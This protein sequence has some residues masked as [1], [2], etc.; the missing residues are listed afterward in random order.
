MS[1]SNVTPSMEGVYAKLERSDEHVTQLKEV[2]SNRIQAKA[3]YRTR[4]DEQSQLT[5]QEAIPSDL[6]E[7]PIRARIIMGDA[8]HCIAASLDH[9]VYQLSL[10]HTRDIARCDGHRTHFPIFDSEYDAEGRSHLPRI[11]KRLKLM[12]RVPGDIIRNLQPYKRRPKHPHTDPLWVLYRL[13]VIDKHRVLLATG[14]VAK[15]Q[16]ITLSHP[17]FGTESLPV[18]EHGWQPFEANKPLFVVHMPKGQRLHPEAKIDTNITATPV[19]ANTDT[20]VDGEPVFGVLAELTRLIRT[21]VIDVL[22]G[23]VK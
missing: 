20:I 15:V 3:T 16:S 14:R 5:V 6:P 2:F 18:P 13:D 22:A 1:N 7:I 17:E 11:D 21:E 4:L 8:I 19:F 10:S 23:Y 12:D 9:L